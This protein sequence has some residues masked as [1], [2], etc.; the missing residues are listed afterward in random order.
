MAYHIRSISMPPTSHPTIHRVDEELH[1]LK[2]RLASSK[3]AHMVPEGLRSVGDVYEIIE[4]LLR[5][6]SSL[7]SIQSC[8]TK[9]VEEQL[10]CS[11]QLLDLIGVARESL[12]MIREHV[13]DIESA[14]RRKGNEVSETKKKAQKIIKDALKSLNLMGGK[15][16]SCC[17]DY[18]NNQ[19]F[20]VSI[21]ARE[22]TI[23][24][25][26]LVL[27]C[28]SKPKTK[29]SR[30]SFFKSI[31]KRKVACEGEV[32]PSEE[33]IDTWLQASYYCILSN[34]VNA[35]MVEKA[36]NDLQ[37]IAERMESLE[38]GLEVLFKKLVQNRVS[39]LNILSL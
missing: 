2:A 14:I 26:G 10:D 30:W 19:L 11:L 23:S 18:N 4:E 15:S 7:Q 27:S 5:L 22:V 25:L 21:E 37:T 34:D 33:N 3:T 1:N 9:W 35:I 12:V 28:L 6:P 36:H 31:S 8:P 13:K 16:V 29:T 38:S 20:K 24:L 17:V 32:A 39:L